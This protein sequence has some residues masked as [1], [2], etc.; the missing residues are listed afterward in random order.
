[1][2]T[3]RTLLINIIQCPICNCIRTFS[4]RSHQWQIGVGSGNALMLTSVRTFSEHVSVVVHTMYWDFD[5]HQRIENMT[6]SAYILALYILAL[7]HASICMCVCM[8]VYMCMYMY[9]Y[10][11][12]YARMS[13]RVYMRVCVYMYICMYV[14]ARIYMHFLLWQRVYMYTILMCKYATTIYIW[15]CELPSGIF[16][17]YIPVERGLLTVTKTFEPATHH[18]LAWLEPSQLRRR[19]FGQVLGMA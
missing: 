1:M 9:V 4:C 10:M 11:C 13:L 3:T 18:A 6:L 12:V 7:M 16:H 17:Q 14:Y 19:E 8:F 5:G 2:T 15:I